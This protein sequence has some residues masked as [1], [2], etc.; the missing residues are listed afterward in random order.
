ML[1]CGLSMRR[2]PVISRATR[3]LPGILQ[4]LRRLCLF[5]SSLHLWLA[6]FQYE[7]PRFEMV[8]QALEST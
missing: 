4:L 3:F 5:K 1:A 8:R 7:K 6:S 2:L